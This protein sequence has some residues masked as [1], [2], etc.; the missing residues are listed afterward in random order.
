M[1]VVTELILEVKED[2]N[3]FKLRV[4]WVTWRVKILEF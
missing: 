4:F 2:L 3:Q 1:T